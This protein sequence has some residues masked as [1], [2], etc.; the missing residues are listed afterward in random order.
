MPEARLKREASEPQNETTGEKVL[1]V[2]AFLTR[3]VEQICSAMSASGV[4][5]AVRDPEGVRCLASAGD[6]PA[7]GS[8]L[9]PDSTFTRACLESGEVVLC[10]DAENDSRIHRS[11]AKS[12]NLRSAVAV[13]IKANGSVLGVIEVFSSR[14][15]DI[16]PTDVPALEE[17]AELFAAII[18]PVSTPNAHPVLHDS[19]LPS[20]QAEVPTPDEEQ[21][22]GRQT[23][24]MNLF[25]VELGLP[26][27]RPVDSAHLPI[28]RKSPAAMSLTFQRPAGNSNTARASLAGAVPHIFLSFAGKTTAARTWRGRAASVSFLALVFFFL[29]FFLF[30]T[31]RP[32]GMK[33]SPKSAAAP[34]AGL[35]KRNDSAS[36]GKNEARYK[37][38]VRGPE[39]AEGFRPEDT[40]PSAPQP[41]AKFN[42]D[43]EE[44]AE[45]GKARS[46]PFTGGEQIEADASRSADGLDSPTQDSKLL[47][48]T[49]HER[50]ANPG[51]SALAVEEAK[52][53]PSEPAAKASVPE[54]APAVT[55]A[56]EP[57]RVSR[58]DFV[59]AQTLKGHS[60]WVTG[61]AFSS[62]GQKLASG[63]WDQTVKLWDVPTGKEL[64]VVGSKM[65]EVQALAFSRDGHWLAAENSNDTVTLWDATSQREIH[66]LASDKR[67]GPLGTNWVY[68]IAFSPDGRWLASGVDDKTVRIW[69]VRSGRAVRDLTGLR[70]SVIYAAFSPDGRWLASGDDDKSI[71]IW[72]VS[73]GKEIRRLTGHKK[74]IYAVA[75]SPN[76]RWLA[77]ASADKTVKLWDIEAGREVK[78][79]TGHESQ[80]TSVT[81]SLDGRWLA[82]GSRDK[83]I[84]IWDVE[85]WQEVQTL[86]GLEHSVYTVAFDF[87]GRWL[88]SGSEDGT[89][90]LW[91]LR[92]VVD[93]TQLP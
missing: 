51:S 66:T 87:R 84:K 6:A 90:N 69:D 70:R 68:S 56:V 45:Q 79:L 72:E 8:R 60:G 75:F 64:N 55:S 92:S 76:G 74:P 89:I 21:R 65:K 27:E 29:F 73:S 91:R 86:G 85:T 83:T 57:A 88:A 63:S 71:R 3:T 35:A 67:L 4:V 1:Q 9:Q 39:N 32:M 28:E 34:A 11:V 41:L 38:E 10:E 30:G 52:L 14:P 2:S 25:P 53:E 24:S 5:L 43:S 26:P 18:G 37:V 12:L 62:D 61:V 49:G 36:T 33:T 77:S 81:F 82:S 46:S 48:S 31:S 42:E 54:L 40:L 23:V 19:T 17:F 59:L 15:S 58:P 22:G 80:V 47:G 78:T 44:G 50:L 93:H 13:P 16:Y 7:V 20:T